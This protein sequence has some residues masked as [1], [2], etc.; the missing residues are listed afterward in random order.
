ML[1]LPFPHYRNHPPR[2]AK[3]YIPNAQSRTLTQNSDKLSNSKDRRDEQPKGQVD[4]D[5]QFKLKGLGR[6]ES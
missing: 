5:G 4:F 2:V 3:S 1:S 6:W